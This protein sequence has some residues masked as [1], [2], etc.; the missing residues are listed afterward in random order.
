MVNIT[1]EHKDNI[2]FL[3]ISGSMSFED[4]ITITSTYMPQATCHVLFDLTYATMDESVTFEKLCKL[5]LLAKEQITQRAPNGKSAHVSTDM[6]T[7][8]MLNMV[9]IVLEMGNILQKQKVFKSMHKAIEWLTEEV[10]LQP[11]L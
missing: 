8:G 5:P 6:T 1:V 3:H 4:I 2:M 7:F 9:S 11:A 10:P